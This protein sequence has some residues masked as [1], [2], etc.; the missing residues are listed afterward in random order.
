MSD[1]PMHPPGSPTARSFGC[2]C[3]PRLNHEGG[4]ACTTRG[5]ETKYV[6]AKRCPMHGEEASA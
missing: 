1:V 3:D 5:G 6:I 2:T 4:G